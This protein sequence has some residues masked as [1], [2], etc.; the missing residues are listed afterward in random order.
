MK[1]FITGNFHFI[2]GVFCILELETPNWIPKRY[3]V[4]PGT[5]YIVKNKTI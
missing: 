4:I 1:T 2:D 5:L 3:R